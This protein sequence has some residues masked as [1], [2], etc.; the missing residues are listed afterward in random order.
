[1]RCCRPCPLS[2]LV[3]IISPWFDNACIHKCR[4][5]VKLRNSPFSLLPSQLLGMRS[6]I[7][8]GFASTGFAATFCSAVL[9]L[10]SMSSLLL[11]VPAISTLNC[12]IT[13]ATSSLICCRNA[14][15]SAVVTMSVRKSAGSV[16]APAAAV[17]RLSSETFERFHSWR[18]SAALR[19][20]DK[21][22]SIFCSLSP[23]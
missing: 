7:R 3:R 11:I 2:T 14:A 1:M 6:L 18:H 5:D 10:L 4:S 15:K 13:S 21:R 12:C 22:K 23:T 9:L 8:Y 20:H 19:Y 16:A 17:P